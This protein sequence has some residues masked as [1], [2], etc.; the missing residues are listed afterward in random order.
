MQDREILATLA[1]Y[2]WPKGRL[3]IHQEWSGI[4]ASGAHGHWGVTGS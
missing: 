1:T 4:G 2:L 3:H